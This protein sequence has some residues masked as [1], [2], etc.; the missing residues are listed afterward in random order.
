MNQPTKDHTLKDIQ[1]LLTSCF[2]FIFFINI[3]IAQESNS[4]KAS[5]PE[6]VFGE[7]QGNTGN[8]EYNGILIHPNFI[9]TGYRA[10]MYQN[11]YKGDNGVYFFDAKDNQ[12]NTI[13]YQ[14]EVVAKDSIK[15]KLG[16]NPFRVFVKNQN[17][18]DGKHITIS[19]VPNELKRSWYTTDGENNLEFSVGNQEITFRNKAYTIEEIV[20]FTSKEPREYRFVVKN[21]QEYWMFYFKN[22][23]AHYLQIG[24]NGRAGDLYKAGKE[25][26]N[27]RIK[28]YS[29]FAPSV[30]LSLPETVFGEWQ[31]ETGNG[32][33]NGILIHPN[34]IETGYRAF[35]YQNIYKG[36]KGVYFFDAKDNQGNTISYQL[37]VVAKDSIK[38]KLGDN[39]FR[40]FVKHQN[41]LDGKPITAAEV[42]NELKRSWFSTDGKNNLE[43][44]VENEKISFRNKAY[45]IEDVVSFTSKEPR[46]Y[47]FVVKND[48]EYWMFY[49]KNWNEHYLQ[50]G[51]NGKAGDWYKSN[52]EYPDYKI[53]NVAAFMNSKFPKELRGDWLQADGSNV[54]AFSFYYD[55][56]VLEKAIWNYKSVKKIDDIHLIT[57]ERNGKEKTIY[58]KIN[59]D[60]SASFGTN[61]KAL[62]P[63][64]TNKINKPGFKLANDE[65]YNEENLFKVASATYAGIIRGFSVNSKEKTGMV[66]VNNVFTGDQDS[67][68]VEIQDDGSFSVNIP[69]YYPQQVYVKLP[70]YY[71]SVFVEPGKESWQLINPG[72][73]EGEFFA[74]DCA[75]LNTD[76]N[77]LQFIAR[78][79]SFYKNVVS[80]ID[81]YSLEAYKE[82]S[83]SLYTKQLQKRDSVFKERFISNKSRQV[84][85]IGIEYRLYDNIV[86][87]DINSR[88][89]DSAKIDN[90][91]LSFITPE[92]YNNKLAVVSSSYKYF[93]N[94]L[95]YLKPM[96]AKASVTHPS[97]LEL[98]HILKE[99]N[100]TLSAEEKE[101]I[102]SHKKHHQEN[103][104][105]LAKQKAF[106]KSHQEVI[107]SLSEKLSTIY[108]KLT[109]EERKEVFSSGGINFDKVE[110]IIKSKNLA[111]SFTVKEKVTQKAQENLLTE[112]EQKRISKFYSPEI[113]EKNQAFSENHKA[114]IDAYIN[115]EFKKQHIEQIRKNIGNSFSTD[116][117]IA[118]AIL[119]NITSSYI[120]LSD[121][122]LS[123]SQKV[124]DYPFITKVIKVENDK[125]KAKIS[126]NKSKT[127]FVVNETPMTEADKV[128]DA[129]IS[130]YQGKVVFVDFWATWCGPC[131]SG[132]KQMQPL[133]EE[134]KDKDVVFVYIT[135]PSSPETT[136]NN[137]IPNIKGEHFRV[138]KD[139]WN[140]LA[141]KF[142][143]SGIPHY[144]LVD[145]NGSVIKENTSDLRMPNALKGLIEVE[146]NK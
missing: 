118:Q 91:Y 132:M 52:I 116:V 62:I 112:E 133:K 9:E 48:Q 30:N 103:A 15:L 51:F 115:N 146:L 89:R 101:L 83:Y 40:V 114:H 82:E 77:S 37:E 141:Q 22:W 23:D 31:G 5:L 57:L 65:P 107:G 129:I 43:F 64:T 97:V 45:T 18:L 139:K 135:D 120:P 49:F 74:G 86:S 70:N 50:V 136:Y 127:D 81:D 7:W 17:P 110:T 28:Y 119:G 27:D 11:I 63:Y 92:V 106:Q 88:D 44:S 85:N 67:Y 126:A 99:K 87:Y 19:E 130:K 56:A 80:N 39:P 41:P 2:V 14:L 90:A 75:Q 137:M 140:Y 47:R 3:A 117:I 94:R 16:D 143:I 96:R 38:L 93:I 79:D 55:N 36:D 54:W 10:F 42:P 131:R 105:A 13:S 125:M 35:M 68:L 25:Y 134:Y 61:E 4:S 138:S 69:S 122:E 144:L 66:Y 21:N 121:T 24:F 60:A 1:K 72:K 71:T 76:L 46:E 26:P 73:S 145:K 113:H 95:K 104:A 124:V 20:S 78:D 84:F 58:G 53:D 109:E 29:E 8:G 128:F 6:T 142:N 108:Q 32:E 98:A 123:T 111:V 34:F 59:K 12:G 100:I 102:A 33:Y